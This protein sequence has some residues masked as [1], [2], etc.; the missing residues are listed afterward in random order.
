MYYHYDGLKKEDSMNDKQRLLRLEKNQKSY[1]DDLDKM[2]E[3]VENL[4]LKFRLVGILTCVI[5]IISVIY[6]D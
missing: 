6:A 2:F 4:K 1:A 5:V 3:Y